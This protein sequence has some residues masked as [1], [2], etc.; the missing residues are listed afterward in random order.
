MTTLE[1]LNTPVA[2]KLADI[3]SKFME[4]LASIAKH[5]IGGIFL[6]DL[7]VRGL[8]AAGMKGL[9]PLEI[10]LLGAIVARGAVAPIIEAVVPF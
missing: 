10:A 3:P 5:D 6:A 7:F 9:E 2:S 8:A 4:L 1:F